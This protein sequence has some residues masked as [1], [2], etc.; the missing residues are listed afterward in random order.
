MSDSAAAAEGLAELLAWHA[1]ESL[2]AEARAGRCRDCGQ[3][4]RVES[5]TPIAEPDGGPIEGWFCDACFLA[6]GAEGFVDA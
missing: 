1:G 4:V 2:T 3:P 6:G 5:C